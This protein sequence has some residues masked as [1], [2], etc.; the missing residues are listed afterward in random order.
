MGK[1]EGETWE[2]FSMKLAEENKKLAKV[3]EESEKLFEKERGEKEKLAEEYT[4]LSNAIV[5]ERGDKEKLAD[6]L[7]TERAEK[8]KAWEEINFFKS[9]AL[10]TRFDKTVRKQL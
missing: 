4:K 3:A 1:D 10:T 7:V 8:E 9:Q 2:A 6:A 5:K